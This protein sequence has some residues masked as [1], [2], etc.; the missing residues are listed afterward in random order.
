MGEFSQLAQMAQHFQVCVVDVRYHTLVRARDHPN[1]RTLQ[2]TGGIRQV[3][4]VFNRVTHCELASQALD[5]N[6]DGNVDMNDVFNRCG[7]I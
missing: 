7:V 1:P 5:A 4:T 2:R 6:G 3:N